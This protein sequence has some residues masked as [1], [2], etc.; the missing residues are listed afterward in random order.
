MDCVVARIFGAGTTVKCT[1]LTTTGSTPGV[2]VRSI[3][4]MRPDVCITSFKH[5]HS[6]PAP[7]D[8]DFPQD[9][10]NP[11]RNP[12]VDQLYPP[13]PPPTLTTRTVAGAGGSV[14]MFYQFS[15][16]DS[17]FIWHDT[18]GPIKDF[19][20]R[21]PRCRRPTWSWALW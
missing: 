8:P 2:E 10:I 16:N 15:I 3:D 21:L 14:S 1:S 17:S 6:G 5:L 13:Q 11:V 12:R 9:L 18:N 19:Q 20:P 4:V 7:L